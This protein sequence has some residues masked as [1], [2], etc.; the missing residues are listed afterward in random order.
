[1]R[2]DKLATHLISR[3]AARALRKIV[4]LV[5]TAYFTLVAIY[6]FGGAALVALSLDHGLVNAQLIVGGI[7]VGLAALCLLIS[8][9]INVKGA[10]APAPGR[11]REALIVMLIE[12]LILGYQLARRRDRES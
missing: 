2:I 5:L 10:A 12:A 6:Y 1:M 8:W 4:L 11:S 7:Y 3:L 9:G